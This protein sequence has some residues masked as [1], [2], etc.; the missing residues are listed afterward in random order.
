MR[1]G[2]WRDHL[3]SPI[4][5]SGVS[6]G[7]RGL[8]GG[9]QRRKGGFITDGQV[10]QDLAVDLDPGLAQAV[11]EHAVTHVV[12]VRRRVDAGDP[13]AA[14]V[15]LLVATVTIGVPPAA[16]HRLLRGTPQLAARAEG[17][18]RGLHDLLFALQAHDV[19]FDSWHGSAPTPGGGA[20]GRAPRRW[21]SRS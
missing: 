12:L 3:T 7:Q 2:R 9:C 19:R 21:F 5:L 8:G 11:H 10:S 14:E 17:A 1:E 4:S 20:S 16:L 18:A 15:A 6:L 13:E